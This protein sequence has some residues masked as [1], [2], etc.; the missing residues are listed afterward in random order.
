MTLLT[1]EI[2]ALVGLKRIYTAPEEL[3]AAAGRYFGL[4]VGDHNPL[5]SDSEYARAQGL[6]GV[7]APLTLICETNQYAD[8]PIPPDGYAG[9]E[10]GIELPGTR[11]VRGGN[12]YTFHRRVRPD[13]VI[14]ATWEITDVT[15]KTTRSGAEM[16]IIASRATYTDQQGGLLAENEETIIFV[17]LEAGK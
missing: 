14:T 11:K 2:R 4:A 7:T 12:S 9:H 8:L 1:D 13:D 10:W 5:Y 6:E 15:E 3:G 16:L 17:A